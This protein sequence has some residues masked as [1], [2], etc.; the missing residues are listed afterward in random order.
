MPK[1]KMVSA[2]ILLLQCLPS[3]AAIF[4]PDDRVTLRSNEGSPFSALG[5]VTVAGGHTYAT[6]F[7]VSPCHVL[8]VKHAVGDVAS[9]RGKS[10]YFTG[11]PKKI[12]RKWKSRGVVVATGDFDKNQAPRTL[13]QGRG[14]DWLLM[15]LD[16]CIG[17]EL[18][19]VELARSTGLDSGIQVES[20]GFPVDRPRQAPTIDPHCRIRAT[21]AAEWFHDCA[22]RPGNSGSPLFS[23]STAQGKPRLK[24]YAMHTAGAPDVST[25]GF[26]LNNSGIAVPMDTILSMIEK[27][28]HA[29]TGS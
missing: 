3:F 26:S 29:A 25:Q 23:I 8:T 22:T 14:K 18:G 19:Y 2:G 20:A 17:E 11:G 28:L 4:G 6:G 7:L 10:L 1:F 9:A 12:D 13:G 21:L 5:I 15:R 24:V 27:P 16:K